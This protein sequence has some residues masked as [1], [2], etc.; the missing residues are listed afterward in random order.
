MDFSKEYRLM[1]YKSKELQ[2]SWNP[3]MGDY[4]F[5]KVGYCEEENVCSDD[6]PCP[7]CLNRGNIY[8]ISGKY[9]YC[10]S[11]GGTH[12]F[13]GGDL[14]SRDGG[15]I[16]NETECYVMTADGKHHDLCNF[17]VG[18]K[19]DKIWLPRQDQLQNMFLEGFSQHYKARRFI[20][21]LDEGVVEYNP[22]TYSLE[23]LWLQYYMYLKFNKTWNAISNIKRWE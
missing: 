7:E 12:W 9:D 22:H 16:A 4:M 20:W 14:C 21:W 10:K 18:K 15:N 23:M 13:Y 19:S 1:C 8:V 2:N 6:S 17:Q 11:I 3:Q 5:C